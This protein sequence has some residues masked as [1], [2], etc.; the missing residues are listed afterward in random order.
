[1]NIRMREDHYLISDLFVPDLHSQPF[2][3]FDLEGTGIHTAD[4]Y[5]T[6]LAAVHV[7]QEG[8]AGDSFCRPV[9][10][11]KPVPPFV[12]KL[13]GIRNEDLAEAPAFSVIYPLFLDFIQNRILVTQAGYE[14]DVPLLRRLCQENRLPYP[15]NRVLDLK[16]LVKVIHPEWEGIVS[17]DRLISYY[18]IDASGYKR[19]DALGDCHLIARLFQLV[20]SEYKHMNVN[21]LQLKEPLSIARFRIEGMHTEPYEAVY[22]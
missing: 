3:V 1:M 13:T 21:E 6:Q 9:Y 4:D 7:D 5:V 2:C 16:V 10:T 22:P 11:P 14:Y 15:E 17:T 8:A 20:L 12:E 18:G 19:H